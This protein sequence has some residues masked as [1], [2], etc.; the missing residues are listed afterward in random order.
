MPFRKTSHDGELFM[1]HRASPGIPD[2]AAARLGL[3]P[4]AGRG[5]Y[6]AATIGCP[7]C[8]SAVVLNPYRTRERAN[9]AKCNRY[10]C[11]HCAAAMADPDYVHRTFAEIAEMVRS[12]RWIVTGSPS[13]PVLTPTSEATNG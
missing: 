5:V 2:E 7:H 3:P 6:E 1:D 9:C 10:I 4:G 8:G 13:R 11:D 12:G